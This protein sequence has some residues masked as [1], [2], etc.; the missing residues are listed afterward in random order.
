MRPTAF[1]YKYRFNMRVSAR[2]I[3]G[4]GTVDRIRKLA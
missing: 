3:S 1:E 4:D 2:D